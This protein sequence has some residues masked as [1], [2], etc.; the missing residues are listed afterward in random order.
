MPSS[1]SLPI[2][3][4]EMLMHGSTRE[5]TGS[6]SEHPLSSLSGSDNVPAI[7]LSHSGKQKPFVE[8]LYN[9]LRRVNHKAFFDQHSLPKGS[10]FPQRI[11]TAAL[12]CELGVVVLSEDFLTSKWPMVELE[13]LVLQRGP[14]AKVLPLF[15]KLGPAD[16]GSPANL[17]RWQQVWKEQ[18]GASVDI[19][20]NWS[21]AL[22]SLKAFHGEKFTQGTSETAYINTVVRSLCKVV[23]SP[24]PEDLSQIQGLH[25]LA[26]VVAGQFEELRLRQCEEA[27]LIGLHGIGGLGKTTVCKIMTNFYS[28]EYPGRCH[29]LEFPTDGND[30]PQIVQGCKKALKELTHLSDELLLNKVDKFDQVIQLM[31]E[32]FSQLDVF[33]AIDNVWESSSEAAN[34]IL[35]ACFS[36]NSKILLTSRS[37]EVLKDLLR[38][39]NNACVRPLAALEQEEAFHIVKEAFRGD[40]TDSLENFRDE[41]GGGI[42][43]RFKFA[44]NYHALALKALGGHLR[45]GWPAGDSKKNKDFLSRIRQQVRNDDLRML[46]NAIRLSYDDLPEQKKRMFL[47]IAILMPLCCNIG[48]YD[49]RVTDAKAHQWLSVLYEDDECSET[50]IMTHFR[51]LALDGL[52]QLETDGDGERIVRVHDLYSDLAHS[53][54]ATRFFISGRS[55]KPVEEF[56]W[57]KVERV[58]LRPGEQVKAMNATWLIEKLQEQKC[59]KLRVLYA[60]GVDFLRSRLHRR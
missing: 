49:R 31:K 15:Y 9:A 12:G 4:Q 29:H 33:L 14:K 8:N 28:A 60:A 24:V 36:A 57:E 59:Q 52:V 50:R 32:H 58:I 25:H 42:M 56:D 30:M 21:K 38:G 27:C 41:V 45:K 26:K 16:L 10:T 43:Q 23:P 20:D 11:K 1:R 47:D 3:E 13:I 34:R 7:F 54:A 5:A 51:E 2:L 48:R 17:T 39:H 44:G 53:E 6:S 55:N 18:F 19:I 37:D 46:Y 35:R 40:D 22:R